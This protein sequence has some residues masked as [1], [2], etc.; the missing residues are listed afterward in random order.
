MRPVISSLAV[1][2]CLLLA[3]PA[4]AIVGGEETQRDW[5]HMAAMEYRDGPGEEFQFRCGASLVAPD[6]ILTAAHCV[7]NGDGSGTADTL[8]ATDFR[9]LLGT[10]LR[11]SGGERIGAVEI[12]EHPLW[13]ESGNV[14]GDVALVKL[15]R[16]SS[17]GTPIELAQ[18]ADKPNWEPGDPTTVIGWGG[19][20]FIA[21]PDA[22]PVGFLVDNTTNELNEVTIPI[23]SDDDCELAYSHMLVGFDPETDVC[24]G[25]DTGNKD[26]CQGDSGGPLMVQSGGAWKQVGVVSEGLGC[27][28]PT[29]YGIYAEAGGDVLRPWI[30]S[31]RD[32]M[33]D[34]DETT[35]TTTTTTTTSGEQQGSTTTT[36]GDPA[37]APAPAPSETRSTTASSSAVPVGVPA[38]TRARFAL[39]SSLGSLR[40]AKRRGAFLVQLRF[41]I[42]VD[43]TATLK[44]RGRLVARGSRRAV[45]NGALRLRFVKGR[46]AK[47]GKAV[48]RIVVTNASGK[49]FAASRT[50]RIAR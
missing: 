16:P 6:V 41:N 5:P 18:P 48:L 43:V 34:A 17:L 12:V 3:A 1:L 8:T 14:S 21:P 9:F 36:S 28:Y 37:P 33:S 32:A 42:P 20:E 26:S 29:Q 15:E 24:A 50:V 47:A 25:E 27:A 31:N 39:P 7:D 46:R 13:D 45:Q 30:E 11:D 22:F 44:Q 23:V 40:S 19:K 38:I 10:K 35:T 2:L 49:R 4:S